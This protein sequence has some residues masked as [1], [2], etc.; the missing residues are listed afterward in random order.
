MMTDTARD[1]LR[2][3]FARDE[4]VLYEAHAETLKPLSAAYEKLLGDFRGAELKLHEEHTA[5]RERYAAAAAELDTP[6]S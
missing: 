4:Q 3:D 6:E 1:T 5:L 2:N